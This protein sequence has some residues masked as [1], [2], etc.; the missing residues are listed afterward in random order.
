MRALLTRA[1]ACSSQTSDIAGA[2][3]ATA[4]GE[5]IARDLGD[6]EWLATA[7]TLHVQLRGWENRLDLARDAAD[8]ADRRPRAPRPARRRGPAAHVPGADAR[9]P[10]R[11][12]TWPACATWSR[13][14]CRRRAAAT[15]RAASA[16]APRWPRSPAARGNDRGLASALGNTAVSLYYLGRNDQALPLLTEQ[17]ALQRKIGDPV[18]L[19]TALANTGEL[20]GRLGQRRGRPGDDRG[21]GAAGAWRRSGAVRGPDRGAGGADPAAVGSPLRPRSVR[22]QS[23]RPER[24]AGSDVS[25]PDV[26]RGEDLLRRAARLGLPHRPAA[27]GGR[28]HDVL[29]GRRAWRRRSRRCGARTRRRA[30]RSTS[31]RT[32]PTPSAAA[33]TA[34]RRPG[35][36]AADG[37]ASTPGACAFA[38]RSDRRHLRHLA[39]GRPPRH[40]DGL[41]ARRRGLDRAGRHATC[42]RGGRVLRRRVRPRDRGVPGHGRLLA[43]A[44]GRRDGGRADRARPRRR[45]GADGSHWRVYVDGGRRRRLVRAGGGAGRPRRDRAVRRARTSAASRSS[46]TR[47]TSASASSSRRSSGLSQSARRPAPRRDAAPR[48]RPAPAP[49]GSAGPPRGC[50]P[51]PRRAARPTAPAA[52]SAAARCRAAAPYCQPAAARSARHR[53]CSRRASSLHLVR[54]QL[55]VGHAP[56]AERHEVAADRG[57]PRPTARRPGAGSTPAPPAAAG[58]TGCRRACRR[59]GRCSRRGWRAPPARARRPRRSRACT[60]ARAAGTAITPAAV[61]PSP[62]SSERPPVPDVRAI[63]STGACRAAGGS[64]APS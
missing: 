35:A 16:S 47:S 3:R 48:A 7:L 42:E 44:A 33:V 32:T 9:R 10:S 24:R 61:A 12:T 11:P 59:R 58:P 14:R 28:L 2:A 17:I 31:R 49:T 60:P 8:R 5:F 20:N 45:S 18:A 51:A 63:T 57:Q 43:P 40:R 53:S 4:E 37:H 13:R 36:G 25:V 50:R 34:Q 64:G 6:L 21:G 1:P 15:T 19:A 29:R 62:S 38:L 22:W 55:D 30:G 46:A 41:R 26:E 39:E 56:A 23:D 54:R 27:R 52:G